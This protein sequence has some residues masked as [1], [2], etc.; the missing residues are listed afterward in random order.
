MIVTGKM[1]LESSPENELDHGVFLRSKS[2]NNKKPS[3]SI[4]TKHKRVE[5]HNEYTSEDYKK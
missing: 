4:K 5:S 1:K 2:N 3:N